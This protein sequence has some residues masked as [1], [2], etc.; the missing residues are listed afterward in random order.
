MSNQTHTPGD[1][2]N[3]APTQVGESDRRAIVNMIDGAVLADS[4]DVAAF[5]SKQH[6]AV[7]RDIRNLVAKEATLGLRN[8]VAFK[9]NDLTGENTSHY[10]M[11][12]DGFTLLAMGFT[13][14]KALKWKLSYIEAFNAMEAALRAP[15]ITFDPSDPRML[16][17]CFEHLQS[18][19]REKDE[20]IATQGVQVKKL[21]RL[22]GAKGTMCIS[23]AAK[24]LGVGRDALFARMQ[25]ERW[26]FK[27]AGNKN[28]LAYDDKRRALLLDHDDHLYIDSEGRERVA[29]R[30]LVTAKGL[31]KLAEILNRPL[32]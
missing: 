16:L 10:L 27:R 22:E 23:D 19:V 25:A 30:V 2:P 26:I 14:Q 15:R 20:I 8:F 28:W 17:A 31:V 9:N 4:R 3:K 6:Y 18:Q 7:L 32:H 5:F 1:E 13:G 24:T 29:T 21:E 12:R 11:D